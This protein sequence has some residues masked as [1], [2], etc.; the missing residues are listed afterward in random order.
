MSGKSKD[1]SKTTSGIQK[2]KQAYLK[3]HKICQYC[4]SQE[5]GYC[6]YIHSYDPKGP[7]FDARYNAETLKSKD[8]LIAV[9]KACHQKIDDP[10]N[11][12]TPGVLTSLKKLKTE[13]QK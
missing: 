2:E 4:R 11:N 12:F 1:S 10:K 9:C 5:A 13:K 6:A 3:K 7:R 8:N